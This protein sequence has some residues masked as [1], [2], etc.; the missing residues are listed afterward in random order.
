M[1]VQ[2]VW[3]RYTLQKR[4]RWFKEQNAKM[5][6]EMDKLGEQND[7]RLLLSAKFS[8]DKKRPTTAAPLPPL[9]QSVFTKARMTFKHVAY[10]E[11]VARL[12]KHPFPLVDFNGYCAV[13]IQAWWRRHLTQKILADV[14]HTSSH[15]SPHEQIDL[16]QQ[17]LRLRRGIKIDAVVAAQRI[18]RI[19]RSYYNRKVFKFMKQLLA[20]KQSAHPR[21][22]L[23]Y[24]NPQEARLMDGSMPIHIRLRFGGVPNFLLFVFV[25]S[26]V[27]EAL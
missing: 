4:Y 17:T 8:A 18:Q 26:K 7:T 16:F 9:P 25:S 22:L 14:Q 10:C 20:L 11:T 19:W 3:R 27:D 6:A 23:H 15:L 5:T 24:I 21:R 12:P 1:M 2:S 13:R